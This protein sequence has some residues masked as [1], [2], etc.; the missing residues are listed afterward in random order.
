MMQGPLPPDFVPPPLDCFQF[1]LLYLSFVELAVLSLP[2]RWQDQI[3]RVLF[4]V[5]DNFVE[6]G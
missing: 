4:C 2:E 5:K 6:S 1:A 3:L